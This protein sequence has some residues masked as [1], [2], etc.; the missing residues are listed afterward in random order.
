[1]MLCMKTKNFL[2]LIILIAVV[3]QS[4]SYSSS[5][6]NNFC[7]DR[8][9]PIEQA[10]ESFMQENNKLKEI[11]SIPKFNSL[12]WTCGNLYPEWSNYYVTKDVL[13]NKW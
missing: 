9:S 10:K 11:S 6:L 7:I 5:E 4:C 2:T 13:N 8:P 1:M 3:A 12:C